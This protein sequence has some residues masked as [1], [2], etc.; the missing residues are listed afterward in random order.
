MGGDAADRLDCLTPTRL[1]GWCTGGF[2]LRRA[3]GPVLP[4]PHWANAA[5]AMG[6]G[7]LFNFPLKAARDQA[8]STAQRLFGLSPAE[9]A[10]E[11]A[12]LDR[13]VCVLAYLITKPKPPANLF[14]NLARRFEEHDQR[15]VIGALLGDRPPGPPVV[16]AEAPAPA[17]AV[18]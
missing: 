14:V 3:D 13:L 11:V 8:W 2:G 7:Q 1:A 4:L 10:A 5:A 6:G 18:S 17:T 12:E 15:V 9:R 16:V